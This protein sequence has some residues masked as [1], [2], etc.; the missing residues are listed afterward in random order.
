MLKKIG[1]GLAVVLLALLVAIATRPDTFRVERSTMIAAPSDVV[2]DLVNDFD[3]WSRWS[4]W[5]KLDP[6][7]TR[8]IT[9]APSG[10][11]AVYRWSGNNKAGEGRMAITESALGERI[12]IDL[13]FER[14]FKSTNL[15]EFTFR[16]AADSVGVTWAMSGKHTLPSKA[17]SLVASMDKMVG[18]DFEEGLA[19]LKSVA[20]GGAGRRADQTP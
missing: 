17:M 15:T 5:E 16:P 11:G 19:K 14:P 7:M 4:P 1:I 10:V 3:Q 2:F 20:E 8:T 13:Q 18:K 6:N 9:G 12:V